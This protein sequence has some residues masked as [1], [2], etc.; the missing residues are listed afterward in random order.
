MLLYAIAASKYSTSPKNKDIGAKGCRIH[1]F[2]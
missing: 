1:R 2:T